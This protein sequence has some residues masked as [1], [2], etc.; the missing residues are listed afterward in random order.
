MAT[1][2]RVCKPRGTR[3]PL[4]VWTPAAARRGR[5]ERACPGPSSRPAGA[6]RVRRGP[7]PRSD[8]AAPHCHTN[9]PR[10]GRHV[11]LRA[12]PERMVAPVTYCSVTTP[13]GTMD[14]PPSTGKTRGPQS[15]PIR[16]PKALPRDCS[17]HAR[18]RR[19]L[20]PPVVS[21][22][23]PRLSSVPPSLRAVTA[24]APDRAARTPP[25]DCHRALRAAGR[26]TPVTARELCALPGHR[27]PGCRCHW[28]AGPAPCRP[29]PHGRLRSRAGRTG[30]TLSPRPVCG[31]L[32]PDSMSLHASP[33]PQTPTLTPA[34]PAL[35]LLPPTAVAFTGVRGAC[36]GCRCMGSKPESQPGLAP[37]AAC[38]E[39]SPDSSSCAQN[40]VHPLHVAWVTVRAGWTPVP[41]EGP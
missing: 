19:G 36:C 3:G 39:V 13:T 8:V 31:S 41:L 12:L 26:L 21:A 7:A 16:G 10:P 22:L 38:S 35:L 14:A 40:R 29:A 5:A 17:A 33:A 24:Q 27:P 20:S 32:R 18:R 4:A 23:R 28:L 25:A 11:L 30:R 9:V 1:Q 2:P 37:A 6:D 34:P 15:S